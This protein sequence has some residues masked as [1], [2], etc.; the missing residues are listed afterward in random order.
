MPSCDEDWANFCTD[1]E[2]ETESM[3]EVTN[4]YLKTIPKKCNDIY[5]S[6]KTKIVQFNFGIINLSEC[7]WLIPIMEYDTREEGVI[8]K[9]IKYNFSCREEISEID[10]RLRKEKYV[11]VQTIISIDN[12]DGKI[13]FKEVRK[14]SVGLCKKDIVTTR[15]KKKSAFYNCFVI[16][17]RLHD[18]VEMVFKECHVK[19]FNTG[20]LEVPGIK[21]DVLFKKVVQYVVNILKH[22]CLIDTRD[23]L[24]TYSQ[25]TVLINSNFNCGYYINREKLFHILKFEYNFHTSYDPCS[26]PGIMSKF[27]YKHGFHEQD[28]TSFNGGQSEISFMIFRTGSVLIV[29]KCCENELMHIYN[30]L[31]RLFEKE[32]NKIIDRNEDVVRPSKKPKFKKRVLHIND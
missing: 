10:F 21:D 14:I 23:A 17:L 1:G 32:C 31:K 25:E 18:D 22:N 7:F 20:K 2:N 5:I 24:T 9:Q 27:Y 28:G 8:K 29:G 12:P 15:T 4:D 30:F 6:T 13:Q 16:I 19:I 3:P 11:D 26:Y